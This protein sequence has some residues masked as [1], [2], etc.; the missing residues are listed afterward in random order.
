LPVVISSRPV[1]SRAPHRRGRSRGFL[2]PRGRGGSTHWRRENTPRPSGRFHRRPGSDSG[3]QQVEDGAGCRVST[4]VG[5][6]MLH[7]RMVCRRKHEIRSQRSLM[8][9]LIV[10]RRDIYLD[11]EGA[12]RDVRPPRIRDDRA[13]FAM[14]LA[15]G[16]AGAGHDEKLRRVEMLKRSLRHRRRCRPRR[17]H[18]P[19][20]RRLSILARMAVTA[21]VNLVDR[22]AGAPAG[23]SVMA[24]ICGGRHLAGHHAVERLISH[25]R[26]E[27]VA[28]DATCPI[29]PFDL[30]HDAPDYVILYPRTCVRHLHRKSLQL[31]VSWRHKII[32]ALLKAGAGPTQHFPVRRNLEEILQDKDARCFGRDALGMETARRA[33]AA[34]GGQRPHDKASVG[35]RRHGE[36]RFGMVSW[37]KP[38][39]S[40]SAWPRKRSVDIPRK[41]APSPAV[42]HPPRACHAPAPAPR[43]TL[44]PNT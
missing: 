20:R 38:L 30:H 39:K 2:Q 15:T 36:F 4:R 37:S 13:R 43:T 35:L 5:A 24:P 17:S 22:L 31:S 3:P 1:R 34:C 21:P 33:P 6:D 8:Q 11:A 16:H 10:F 26:R 9:A 40:D 19:E 28:P 27:R 12:V 23:P 7:G 18:R 42:A 14:A 25:F 32:T 29:Q 41:H 44:A